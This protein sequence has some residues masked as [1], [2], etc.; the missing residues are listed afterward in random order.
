MKG[1]KQAA[2]A[3]AGK[4][5]FLYWLEELTHGKMTKHWFILDCPE[6]VTDLEE[7]D[8][9]LE[10]NMREMMNDNCWDIVNNYAPT[11]IGYNLK[12]PAQKE[13]EATEVRERKVRAKKEMAIARVINDGLQDKE[14]ELDANTAVLVFSPAGLVKQEIQLFD[15]A[16]SI[17]GDRVSERGRFEGNPQTIFSIDNEAGENIMHVTDVETYRNLASQ[18]TL[19]TKEGEKKQLMHD[20]KVN[21]MKD[22]LMSEEFDNLSKEKQEEFHK[23]FED[24]TEINYSKG[25]I[26]YYRANHVGVVYNGFS[27]SLNPSALYKQVCMNKNVLDS[28]ITSNIKDVKALPSKKENED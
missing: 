19:W 13:K 1:K 15:L 9:Y 27:I 18:V 2:T 24:L 6:G 8:A 3:T 26:N 11:E 10:D 14:V 28:K 5:Q 20:L 22:L 17:I 12:T 21:K 23:D 25:H 7:A 4:L 16:K